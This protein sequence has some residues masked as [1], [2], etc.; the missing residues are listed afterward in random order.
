MTT[1]NSPL[2]EGGD[3]GEVCYLILRKFTSHYKCV[4]KFCNIKSCGK[5]NH[6]KARPNDAVA[7]PYLPDYPSPPGECSLGWRTAWPGGRGQARIDTESMV[8][9]GLK[10]KEKPYFHQILLDCIG[11]L[12]GCLER[13][14]KD[15]IDSDT[16]FKDELEMILFK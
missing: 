6:G 12:V 14:N 10:P 2:Y 7:R 1:P 15:E 4:L 16:S 8:R 5:V 3:K 9:K 11:K 13:L